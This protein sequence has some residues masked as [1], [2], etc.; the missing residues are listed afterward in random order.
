MDPVMERHLEATFFRDYQSL[1]DQLLEIV[2]DDDLGFRLGGSTASIGELCREIGEIEHA[3]VESFT[4]FRTDFGYR[5]GDR[6]VERS[7]AAL[8]GWYADLD[9]RLMTALEAL[10]EDDVTRPIS[11]HDLDDYGFAPVPTVQLDIYREAL[12]IFYAKVS[13][14]L[15]AMGRTLPPQWEAWIG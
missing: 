9:T 10:A 6:S 13:V 15:R 2:S 14:Y 7:V 12:L 8:S 1:R 11:R 3:Y 5:Y 4:T